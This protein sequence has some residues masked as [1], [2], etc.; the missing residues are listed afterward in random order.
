[1]ELETQH[2]PPTEREMTEKRNI[3][4]RK[5]P[6]IVMDIEKEK[7]KKLHLSG[8]RKRKHSKKRDAPYRKTGASQFFQLHTYINSFITNAIQGKQ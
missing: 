1:L 2:E 8:E 6:I 7:K 3:N 4:I 5:A